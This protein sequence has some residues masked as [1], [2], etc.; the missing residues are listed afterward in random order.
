MSI[1]SCF[2]EVM[3]LKAVSNACRLISCSP[4]YQ[5]EECSESW[6]VRMITCVLRVD[7]AKIDV[8]ALAFICTHFHEISCGRVIGGNYHPPTFDFLLG[9]AVWWDESILDEVWIIVLLSGDCY[10]N[11]S[12]AVS[13]K[14][15]CL[16]CH[17]WD[18]DV[19]KR[20][21]VCIIFEGTSD[22]QGIWRKISRK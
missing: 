19:R 20:T 18:K 9:A 12:C 11:W 22:F 7:V 14:T 2:S 4:K 16:C 8:T 17:L 13:G 3:P 21:H 6:R 10:F 5:R 1:F 15:N